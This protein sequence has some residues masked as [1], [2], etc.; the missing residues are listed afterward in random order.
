MGFVSLDNFQIARSSAVGM[1]SVKACLQ[2]ERHSFA[3][4]SFVLPNAFKDEETRDARPKD[5][6]RYDD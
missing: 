1:R 5:A 3:L 4:S 2:D 6:C